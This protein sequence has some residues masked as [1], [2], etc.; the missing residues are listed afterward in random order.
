MKRLEYERKLRTGAAHA[1]NAS[2]A[3]MLLAQIAREQRRLRQESATLERRVRRI[4]QRL[5]E[6]AAAEA[7]VAPVVQRRFQQRNGEPVRRSTSADAAPPPADTA[8]MTLLY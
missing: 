2:D 1:R 4:H 5:Q 7:R 8:E 6:L 3:V